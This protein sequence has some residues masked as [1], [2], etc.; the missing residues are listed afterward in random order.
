MTYAEMDKEKKNGMSHRGLALGKLK[1]W[2][3]KQG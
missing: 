3:E 1:E 2:L